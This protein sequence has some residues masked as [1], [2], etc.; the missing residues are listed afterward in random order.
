MSHQANARKVKTK[1]PTQQTKKAAL[2]TNNSND[3]PSH[4]E[5]ALFAYYVWESEGHRNGSE[6]D[7]WLQ[8]EKQLEVACSQETVPV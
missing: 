4:D 1:K 3:K 6:I 5:V 2:I 8:A 7:H